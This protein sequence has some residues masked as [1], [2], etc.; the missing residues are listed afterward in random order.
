MSSGQKFP[1]KKAPGQK[2]PNHMLPV[3]KLPRADAPLFD[4]MPLPTVNLAKRF[5]NYVSA[6]HKI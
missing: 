5:G 3:K 1:G 2:P 6:K 4:K